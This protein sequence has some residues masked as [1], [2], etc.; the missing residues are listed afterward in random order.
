MDLKDTAQ[1]SLLRDLLADGTDPVAVFLL[2]H[3]QDKDVFGVFE[4]LRNHR[5]CQALMKARHGESVLL[6]PAGLSCPAAG[7]AFGF[8]ALPRRARRCTPRGRVQSIIGLDA[9]TS[10]PAQ[11]RCL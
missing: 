4:R 8:R 11:F 3:D 7:A 1:G 2:A 5:Y 9:V 10:D 6:E